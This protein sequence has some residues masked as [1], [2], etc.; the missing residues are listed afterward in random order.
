MMEWTKEKPTVEGWY[1]YRLGE[2]GEASV[3][4]IKYGKV[5][6]HGALGGGPIEGLQGEWSS[7]P[8]P[9]PGGER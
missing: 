7:T 1:W 2:D 6:A 5:W 4:L 9:T 8:I 3:V